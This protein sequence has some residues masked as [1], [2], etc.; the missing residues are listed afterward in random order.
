MVNRI[1]G[2]L[3]ESFSWTVEVKG[4]LDVVGRGVFLVVEMFFLVFATAS[5]SS[6]I[7]YKG[8]RGKFCDF[9]FFLC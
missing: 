7:Y 9:R 6:H 4:L 3:V 5:T 1:S 8:S 2:E